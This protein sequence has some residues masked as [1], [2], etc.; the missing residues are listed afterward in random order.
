MRCIMGDV[1]VAYL[2][3]QTVYCHAALLPPFP[4]LVLYAIKV[5]T[6]IVQV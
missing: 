1:Q 2:V 6:R 3:K 4:T 5:Q